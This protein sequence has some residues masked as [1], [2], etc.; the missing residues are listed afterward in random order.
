[1]EA[2]SFFF[3]KPQLSFRVGLAIFKEQAADTHSPSDR[4]MHL[5]NASDRSYAQEQHMIIL[6]P[7]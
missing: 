3:W 7:N 2:A 5:R 6:I 4:S 1:M